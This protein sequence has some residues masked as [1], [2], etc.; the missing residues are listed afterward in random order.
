MSRERADAGRLRPSLDHPLCGA[1]PATLLTVLTRNGFVH[2]SHL[3][4]AG[5][6]L[7]SALL[8][9]PFSLAEAAWFGWRRRN[10]PPMPAPLF[11]IGHWRSGTTHLYNVLSRD[12]QFGYVPPLAV[13]LPWDMLG[14]GN[15][16]RPLLE[17]ALPEHRYIDNVVVKPDSPQEDEIALANMSPLSFYHGLYFPRRFDENFRRGLFF[18]GCTPAEID[19]WKRRFVY[20][21]EKISHQQGGRRLLIKNPVY[22]ARVAMLRQI[23]PDARFIHI[24][25]DPRAVFVSALN[26]YRIL[27]AKLALQPYDHIDIEKLVLDT[28][29]RIMQTLLDE[30][31]D[32]PPDRFIEIG[33]EDFEREPL[34]A[35][36]RI[37]HAL[38]ISGLEEAR[39]RFTAYLDS[40]Q[41]YAKNRYRM[42]DDTRRQVEQAWAPFVARWGQPVSTVP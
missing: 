19:R 8:R 10:T 5:I 38:N 15:V 2:R 40:V 35:V 25:R 12:P 14:L 1:D 24:H 20:F 9:S 26:F 23:W 34:E 21:L 28:Y 37:Y 31:A 41:G 16:L 27:L 36:E 4:Q 7:G 29:P 13:G 32:L 33:F 18:D 11:I 42:T 6:A 22:S 30:T 17:R 3:P 39:P